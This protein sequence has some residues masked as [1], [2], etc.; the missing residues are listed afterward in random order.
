MPLKRVHIRYFSIICVAV[1]ML[2]FR[3]ASYLIGSRMN[4]IVNYTVLAIS[5][6]MISM[7]A[8]LEK[9]GYRMNKCSILMIL[10][11]FWCLIGSSIINGLCGNPVDYSG[12]LVYFS[13]MI[14]FSLICDLGLWYSPKKFL[15]CFLIDGIVICS[16]NAITMFLYYHQGGMYHEMTLRNRINNNYYFLGEDNASYFWTLPVLVVCWIYYYLF[17]R[18][19]K[20]LFV[21]A[22]FTL[23]VTSAYIYTYSILAML[24]C[25]S[26]PLCL[27]FFGK[28]AKREK[29]KHSTQKTIW[30]FSFMWKIA[31]LFDALIPTR[32]MLIYV[33]PIIQRVFHKNETLSYRTLIWERAFSHII[34]SPVIGYGNEPI[35]V[36]LDKLL[37]NHTHNLILETFYRGGIIALLLFIS[38]LHALSRKT[39]KAN[40]SAL[41]KFISVMVFLFLI[42]SSMYF[43]YYRYHYLI[44]LIIMAHTELFEDKPAYFLF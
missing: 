33:V 5:M 43:A 6:V 22:C 26:V 19:K 40:S 32:I 27:I 38:I 14:A 29:N 15:K 9:Y 41:Y 20:F 17:N 8:F 11:Y 3:P 24:A 39:E 10:L 4:T 25:A 2:F 36:S 37:V 44:L 7:G 23:L 28:Q 16:I 34:K 42:F 31:L 35:I 1:L 21:A 18:R 13:T 12:A 30:N